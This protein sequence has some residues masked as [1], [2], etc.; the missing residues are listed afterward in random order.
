MTTID[1][2]TLPACTQED[3]SDPGQVL[4]CVW[5]STAHGNGHGDSYVLA[6]AGGPGA[7]Y[8]CDTPVTGRTLEG[9]QCVLTSAPVPAAAPVLEVPAQS[10][11][12][13]L[14]APAPAAPAE[15]AHTGMDG[16]GVIVAVLMVAIGAALAPFGKRARR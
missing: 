1:P 8:A 13:A 12:A 16:V 4:P 6:E 15:L 11:A 14:T 10:E 5:D 9:E 7:Y 2:T 3:G